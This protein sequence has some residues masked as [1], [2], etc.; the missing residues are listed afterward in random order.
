MIETFCDALLFEEGLAAASVASYRNDLHLATRLLDKPVRSFDADD[1]QN[2]LARMMDLQRKPASLARMRS[3]LRRYFAW[4]AENGYR[5]DDPTARLEPARLRKPLPR[6][7]GETDVEKL[8]AAPDPATPTGSRGAAMLE[9]LY[10]CGLRVSE[11]VGLR[12]GNL[13]LQDGILRVRGKGQKERIVPIGED[14]VA[15]VE[16]YI[17]S[18]RPQLLKNPLDD[19][20]FLNERGKAITR[21]A[22]WKLIRDYAIACGITARVSP[23]TLRHAFATHLVNHGADLRVV[24]MLLGHSSLS[25][26]QIYTH[27]AE[28]RLAGIFAAHHPRA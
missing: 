24:Q 2:V 21:Q 22:F 16:R 3:S 9:L 8:L 23:H 20:L 7:I 12:L 27:I 18:A 25:T 11:L 4:L 26:T 13:N 19:T 1:V 14:A 15:A 10:A 28:A 6:S 17:H 5:H